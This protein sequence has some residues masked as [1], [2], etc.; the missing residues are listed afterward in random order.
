MGRLN[1]ALL[2]I[3]MLQEADI[4]KII[5]SVTVATLPEWKRTYY[6][7]LCTNLQV[8]TKGL[9][10]SKV[11]TLFPNEHPDSKAHCVNTYEPITKGSIWKAIND[12]SRIFSNSSF[13]VSASDVTNKAVEAND[14]ENSNLFNWF[15]S[16]WIEETVAG[17]AN[18]WCAVYP[19]DYIKQYGGDQVR[20][21][22]SDFLKVIRPD[23]IAFVSDAESSVEHSLEDRVIGRE[24]FYDEA[25]GNLNARTKVVKT[26]NQRVTTK[27]VNPV[28]H[29]F[30]ADYVLRFWKDNLSDE[31]FNYHLFRFKKPGLAIPCF[32]VGGVAVNEGIN[33]SFVAPFI[34]FG[35]LALLQHRNHRAVDLMFSYP[36]MSEIQTP[37]DN[38]C[39]FNQQKNRYVV[40]DHECGRCKGSGFITV[41]SPYKVYQKKI[42]GGLQ[43]D[44]QVKQILANDPVS[45]HTPDVSILTYSKDSWKEYLRM[46]EEAVFVYQKKVGAD[47]ESFESK[48]V[49]MEGKFAWLLVLSKSFFRVL[50]QVIQSME[51]YL[52]AS[53]VDVS[54]EEPTS[55]AILTESEAFAFLE[56]I[57]ASDTPVYIKHQHIEN[58]VHKFISKSSPIVKALRIL[59][60]VDPLL[61]Y[62]QKDVQTF[63]SNNTIKPETWTTH[64]YAYP[65]LMQLYEDDKQLFK[66]DDKTIIDTL[67]KA[68]AE[69]TPAVNDDLKD[70]I[71]KSVA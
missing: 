2:F 38:N 23:M 34:P 20:F 47:A 3:P 7:Q 12:I 67:K 48:M 52:A 69:H 42:D 15:L 53:P 46:A 6:E 19:P 40:G 37:C 22:R 66:K 63:K 13:T 44:E 70:S 36:R 55:F 62:T 61:F 26:Y 14:F 5:K 4:Q 29:V 41:Q 10:F 49:D 24:V 25:V 64:I 21:I 35:N 60:K 57:V 56:K 27:V 28:Y 9:L 16:K 32:E 18:S 11:D 30:T 54:I 65:L 68:I 33:E 59:K 58:F 45:F 39:R 50:R 71:L 43:S 8:H 17:D 51:N 1:T 31:E